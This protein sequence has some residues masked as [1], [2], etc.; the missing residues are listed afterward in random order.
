MW[1]MDWK[2]IIP[3]L[4][5][6]ATILIGIW[7][8]GDKQD[9]ISR[10]PFLK[11]QL[12]LAFDVSKTVAVLATATDVKVWNEA[13]SH[14]WM[15]Y[16]GPLSIVED[17]DVESAMIELGE[18]VP[19]PDKETPALPMSALTNLSYKLAHALRDLVLTSWNV[20]LPALDQQRL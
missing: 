19:T 5:T 2:T 4:L 12:D 17:Q 9:Q 15:L 20:S 14:F 11:E 6:L 18:I 8:Y 16:W 1:R 3:W 10:E 7:Q 13:R